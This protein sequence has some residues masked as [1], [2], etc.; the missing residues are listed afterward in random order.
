MRVWDTS[1]LLDEIPAKKNA[2]AEA[3][4]VYDPVDSQVNLQR[5]RQHFRQL[6]T[7]LV[8]GLV[9]GFLLPNA[10]LSAYFHFQF[11]HTLKESAK[12]NLAAVAESQKN[13][14]DLYL[15]ERVVNLYNLFHSK[16][17]SLNPSQDQM[18]NSLANLKHFNDGFVD[19]GFFNTRGVQIGYAG[20]YPALQG[21]DYSN[22]PWYQNLLKEQKSYLISDIYMG[23]RRVP[24]FTIATKQVFDGRTYVMRATLDPDKFYIFLR[25]IS[26]GKEVESTLINQQGQYQVVDP[27]RSQLPGSSDFVPTR[28]CWSPMPGSRKPRGRYSPCSR[29]PLPRLA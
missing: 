22:E 8:L 24:H 12:L 7:R 3:E 10:L 5:I 25:A 17:F 14:I 28:P 16:D 23:F 20:P 26:Q 1:H 9:L 21:R 2:E 11:T 27:G 19:V 4:H 15:Q 6:Q 18:D 29:W 13:T